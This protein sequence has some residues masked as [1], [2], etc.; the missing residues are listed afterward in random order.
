M[1]NVPHM[2]QKCC[3]VPGDEMQESDFVDAVDFI[4]QFHRCRG[5]FSFRLWQPGEAGG[6]RRGSVARWQGP[7]TNINDRQRRLTQG[8]GFHPAISAIS[9]H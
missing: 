7:K 8:L 1:P 4:R 9:S 5:E 3:H 6:P 2:P